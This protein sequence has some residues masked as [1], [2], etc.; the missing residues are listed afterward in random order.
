MDGSGSRRLSTRKGR[1]PYGSVKLYIH[2]KR[3]T[4]RLMVTIMLC[5]R[6][7]AIGKPI[8]LEK[9]E[10]PKPRDNDVLVKV[11]DA[12]ICGSDLHIKR[13]ELDTALIPM[14][15]GHEGAGIVEEVGKNVTYP[16]VG[17][18]VAI[19]YPIGCGHCRFCLRGYDN[20]CLSG[21]VG[22]T[23][24]GTWAEYV[25]IPAANAI[26]FSENVDFGEAAICGCA[27]ATPFHG[28]SQSKI[29]KGDNVVVFGAG[30]IGLH[31]VMWSK[32]FGAGKILVVDRKNGRLE[33]AKSY[34]AD[35]TINSSIDNVMET[36]KKETNGWGAD[37][38]IEC[39]GADQY[40]EQALK[41]IK[42]RGS[43]TNSGTVVSI[44]YRAKPFPPIDWWNL[45]E[46]SL[47]VSGS[48]VKCELEQ[49]IRLLEMGKIDLSRS[50]THR[51]SL[52]EVNRG[53]ELLEGKEEQV[54]RIVIEM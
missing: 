48:H 53:F 14:T 32:F 12:G 8:S 36:I 27:V 11:K 21:W 38:A 15:L 2:V 43:K 34:G 10:I 23:I 9:M 30:G 4:T 44:G 54:G 28:V 31:S 24:D 29:E 39:T 40:I 3:N 19:H 37:V 46:G 49:I 26:V 35:V 22:G 42:L 45:R 5:A 47:M 6:V 17:D 1:S 25:R 13:G 16:K 51:I 20:R 50:I 52:Q 18:R 7:M 41:A 33:L